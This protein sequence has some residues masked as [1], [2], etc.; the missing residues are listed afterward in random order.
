MA[1]TALTPR[2]SCRPKIGAWRSLAAHSASR[3]AVRGAC[4]GPNP[5]PASFLSQ[6]KRV[7]PFHPEARLG[8]RKCRGRPFVFREEEQ[9]VRT[10]RYVAAT[11]CAAAVALVPASSA[12]AANTPGGQA[13]K[14][15][16]AVTVAGMMR[17]EQALQDIA[18]ANGNTRASGTPGLP[19]VGRLRRQPARGRGLRPGRPAVRLRV[20]PGARR[21]RTFERVSPD[22]EDVRRR[23]VADFAR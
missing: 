9:V 19:G 22:P 4:G 11:I 13:A 3:V 17:H 20:L 10:T 1:S 16:K 14:L 18:T 12:T 8:Q 5:P 6:P 15:R 7:G 23:G 21:R 2:N